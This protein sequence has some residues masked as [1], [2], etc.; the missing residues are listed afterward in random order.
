MWWAGSSAPAR[1][2]APIL[3]L[4]AIPAAWLWSS[5]SHLSTRAVGAAALLAKPLHDDQCWQSFNAVCSHSTFATDTAAPLSGSILLV[6]V[7]LGMPSFFRQTP[8]DAVLR[9]AIWV[10]FLSARRGDSACAREDSGHAHGLCARHS[11]LTGDCNHVRAHRC[12]GDGWCRRREPGKESAEP[13]GRLRYGAASAWHH[14]AAGHACLCRRSAFED[15]RGHADASGTAATAGTLLLAPAIV[16]GG[17]YELRL[18][19]DATFRKREARHRPVGAPDQ[20]LESRVGFPRRRL[21]ARVGRHRRIARDRRGRPRG[22]RRA[23][24][25]SHT[26]MGA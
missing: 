11:R 23:D 2:L 15:H 21:N 19:S 20:D 1:F 7:S 13:A 26:N 18:A 9:A 10:G 16:P 24:A 25:S 17:V 12:L 3:P 4:L 22:R 6:D 8:G 14:H 5:T